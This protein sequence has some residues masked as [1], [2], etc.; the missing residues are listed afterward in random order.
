MYR[1]VILFLLCWTLQVR[2]QVEVEQIRVAMVR[3]EV[4]K[5]FDFLDS[6]QLNTDQRSIEYA[7]LQELKG[8]QYYRLNDIGEAKNLWD[9]ALELRQR[10]FGDSSAEAGVGY[11]Y[12]ARYHNFMAGLQLDHQRVAWR[13]AERARRM[14]N[15]R[16]GQILPFERTLAHREAGYAYKIAFGFGELDKHEVHGTARALFREALRIATQARDTIWMAQV[17]HDIGNTFTDEILPYKYVKTFGRWQ[18]LVDSARSNYQRSIELLEDKDMDPSEA[19]MMEHFTTSLLLWYAYGQDSIAA[20][21]A[22]NDRALRNMLMVAGRTPDLDP[23]VYE[24]RI[25]NKAQMVELLTI[26]AR[27]LVNYPDTPT[28]HK[29]YAALGAVKAAE[30][31]WQ[32]MLREYRSR[33]YYK[34]AGSYNHFPFLFGTQLLVDLHQATGDE[35]HLLQAIEWYDLNCDALEQRDRARSGGTSGSTI[36]P[37]VYTTRSNLPEGTL[38]IAL[39]WFH[40]VAT[41][42]V[43]RHT[44][45][46]ANVHGSWWAASRW[47]SDR[48]ALRDAMA[49]NDPGTYRRIAY[50]IYQN[51]IQTV[52]EGKDHRELVIVP[53]DVFEGIP[54]EA[55][56]T[57]TLGEATWTGLHYLL[58]R[59]TI[60]YARSIKEA[61]Q[62]PIDVRLQDIRTATSLS[63]EGSHLPFGEALVKKLRT[64]YPEHPPV[65]AATRYDV[66]DLLRGQAP[67]HLSSHAVAPSGPDEVPYLLLRDGPLTLRDIDSAGCQ[68]PF[69]VL[70]TCSSGEGRAFRG[71]GAISLG[72]AILRGGA[73][74]VVQTLWPVDDQATSEILGLMYDGMNEG[75]SISDALN[76]AKRL[77]IRTHAKDPLS[78]PFYWSGIVVTGSVVKPLNG[79]ADRRWHWF[80]GGSLVVFLFAGVRRYKRSKRAKSSRALAES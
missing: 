57:D 54:F 18:Q 48:Q 74:T 43:D 59:Y 38:C 36:P 44:L 45:G 8:E 51:T 22:A 53:S 47:P 67:F 72:N 65:E 73:H 39:L 75:L 52:L 70:S 23:L 76:E 12:Q 32:A 9:T 28:V 2:A 40:H 6:A 29:L 37:S 14:I 13:E 27:T 15:G 49:R 62:A 16:K 30:P 79:A 34:V 55:L 19:M 17:I 24:P 7:R 50:G 61:L 1:A 35:R 10:L 4:Q 71:E 42:S 66:F 20:V 68:A 64:R 25:F 21:I 33:D 77:F 41:L 80:A 3:G 11:A 69:A 58:D 26:R 56:V 46:A 78:S 63:A 31:Y 5:A 60:R